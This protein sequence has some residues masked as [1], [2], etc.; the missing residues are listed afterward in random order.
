MLRPKLIEGFH[1][2]EFVEKI[3]YRKLGKTNMIVSPLSI[4]SG[5]ISWGVKFDKSDESEFPVPVSGHEEKIALMREAVKH[6]INYIDTAPFYG[7]GKSE[8]L[9][10]MAL[11]TLPRESFYIATKVGRNENCDFDYTAKDVTRSIENSLKKLNVTYLDVVQIHDVE[12][13]DDIQFLLDETLPALD[14]LRK[15]GKIRYIGV[16]AYPIEPLKQVIDAS[17]IQIDQ[18][19]SYCR[20]TLFDNELVKYIDHFRSK[21]LGIINA[22]VHGMNL[23]TGTQLPDWHPANEEVKVACN[24]ATKYC[25]ENDVNIAKITL[26]NALLSPYVDTTLVGMNDT[27]I[28]TSNL[29]ILKDGLTDKE[30]QVLD[31]IKKNIMNKLTAGSWEGAELAVY[32]KDPQ[33]YCKKLRDSHGQAN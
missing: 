6:G 10:G 13:V 18:V 8:I 28:V 30:K 14:K 1:V 11:K 24:E 31:H 3:N 25:N 5:Q 22:A 32:R 2:K 7:A 17:T 20:H 23:L 21:N 27:K 16:T 15:E 12:F 29:Q 4:G 19:L 26:G 9:V 33:Q